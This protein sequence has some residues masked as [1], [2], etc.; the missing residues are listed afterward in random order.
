MLYLRAEQLVMQSDSWA[1]FLVNALGPGPKQ[2]AQI[3]T[4][5]P[6]LYIVEK[7]HTLEL[8]LQDS[9]SSPTY[10]DEIGLPRYSQ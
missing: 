2:D 10:F 4:S 5:T 6:I 7:A 1:Q 9:Y 3:R 8:L